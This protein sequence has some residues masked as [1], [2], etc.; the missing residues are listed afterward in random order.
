[1]RSA[2]PS[3]AQHTRNASFDSTLRFQVERELG[4]GPPPGLQDIVDV[5]EQLL[6]P[7][8]LLLLV[9]LTL[10]RMSLRAPPPIVD[11][12]EMT[13]LYYV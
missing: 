6:A 7:L 9:L 10:R 8:A 3:S 12:F 1:M 5:Y 13:E 11:I 4:D 2:T